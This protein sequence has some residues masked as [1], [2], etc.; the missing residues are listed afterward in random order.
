MAAWL[1]SVVNHLHHQG[2]T[3]DSAL[4]LGQFVESIGE[5]EVVLA[6]FTVQEVP[7]LLWAAL[8][9]A[10]H[11]HLQHGVDALQWQ[12][13]QVGEHADDVGP[14]HLRQGGRQGGREGMIKVQSLVC[15]CGNS[16]QTQKT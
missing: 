14:E 6:D 1:G 12:G 10:L 16:L 5:D 11:K 13:V 4:V 15:V 8:H 3:S 2:Y 7:Q 9:R